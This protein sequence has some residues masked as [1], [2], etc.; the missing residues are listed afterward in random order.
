M[1]I[2][3]A[4]EDTP[5]DEEAAETSS[6]VTK[7]KK[8]DPSLGEEL[9]EVTS[10]SHD[11]EEKSLRIGARQSVRSAC[12][13]A[14]RWCWC[15]A[16]QPALCSECASGCASA[17]CARQR[18]TAKVVHLASKEKED[19]ALRYIAARR[20]MLFYQNENC[21]TLHAT[22]TR[23]VRLEHT[24]RSCESRVHVPVRAPRHAG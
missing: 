21:Y 18:E 14:C 8:P 12:P 24:P 5:R 9:K 17:H 6:E 2:S 22:L 11:A 13:R 4:D 19:G 10:P 3:E 16:S 15:L 1:E 20:L 23:T 7:E